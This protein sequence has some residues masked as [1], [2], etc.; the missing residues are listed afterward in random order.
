ME[1]SRSGAGAMIKRLHLGK[2]AEGGI[3]AALLANQGFAGPESVLEGKFGF[4]RSFSDSPALDRLTSGLGTEFETLNTCIKSYACH[5]NAHAPIE[6]LLSLRK[7]HRFEPTEIS[8]IVV[9]GI[10]KL[11][12]HHALYEPSDLMTAQ[13]SLPFCLALSLYFD[14]RDPGSFTERQLRDFT[15]RKTAHLVRIEV[16]GE[17]E[18]KGWDRAARVTARVK[19]GK[20]YT[21]LVVHFKGT[22]HNPLSASELQEKAKR[23]TKNLI[24][25]RRLDRMTALVGGLE[26][27]KEVS[28]LTS[29]LAID[30]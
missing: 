5:I 11:V 3:T 30:R 7:K 15:I 20:G 21:T 13:Y 16:D 14:P 2:A 24:D 23:L 26:K 28:K 25:D 19:G 4:C 1:F 10:E 29:L 6:G 8:E 18:Q 17:I 9:G 22:P 12:T 27:L